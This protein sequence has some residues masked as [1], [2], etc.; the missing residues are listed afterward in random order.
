LTYRKDFRQFEANFWE[1]SRKTELLWSDI[2]KESFPGSQSKIMYLLKQDGFMKMSE[3]AESL[4]LTAGAVTTAANHLINRNYIERFSSPD[5]RRIIQLRLTALG[6]KTLTDLENKG[7]TYLQHVFQ[8]V[9]VEDLKKMEQLFATA[10]A[11][12]DSLE[13]KK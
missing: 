4:Q 7:H 8:H 5:D 1:L 12:I 9:E 13:K 3:V 10:I 11:N 2:F 6:E